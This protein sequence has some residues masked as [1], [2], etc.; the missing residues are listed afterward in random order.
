VLR[1]GFEAVSLAIKLAAIDNGRRVDGYCA[2][3]FVGIDIIGHQRL[4]IP[5][6]YYSHQLALSVHNRAAGVASD[7]VGRTD[8]IE[9]CCG[10]ELRFF[11]VPDGG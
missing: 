8:E 2:R 7:D 5:V 11:L 4:D 10:I 1:T 6:E 3:L 9:W